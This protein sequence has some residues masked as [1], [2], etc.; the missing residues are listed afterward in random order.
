MNE[1]GISLFWCGIQATLYLLAGGLLYAVMRR[2]GPAPGASAAASTLL[3]LCC[4]SAAAFSPWPRGWT[5]LASESPTSEITSSAATAENVEPPEEGL[6]DTM[7]ASDATGKASLPPSITFNEY[8]KLFRAELEAARTSDLPTG[9]SRR[10]PSIIAAVLLASVA[11]A[12]ARILCGMAAMRR[13]RAGMLAIDD[14]RLTELAAIL[15]LQMGCHR[16][17]ELKQSNSLA[18]P[19]TMGWR[20]PLIVLP[21]DWRA[22]TEEERRVVLAHEIAHIARGDY[23]AWLVAQFSV[24]L[25]VYHPLV[26]WLAGRLR[27]EQELAADDWAAEMSGGREAYLFTLAQMALRQDDRRVAWAARPFLPSRGTFL[28]RIEM[29]SE[30]KPLRNVPVSRRRAVALA[31]VAALAGLI[32]SGVRA[33]FGAPRAAQAAPADKPKATPTTT[34][35]VAAIGLSYVPPRTVALL[36]ARPAD[37]LSD[38][39]MQPLVKLLNDNA[40]PGAGLNIKDIEEIKVAILRWREP[41]AAVPVG[42]RPRT[43]QEALQETMLYTIRYKQ[44]FDWRGKLGEDLIGE[45]VEASIAGKTYYRSGRSEAANRPAMYMPDDRTVVI[46]PEIE[47]QRTI[48][49]A[50]KSKIEW[51]GEWE[52]SAKGQAAVMVDLAA[53]NRAAGEEISRQP[54]QLG[55]MAVFTP[56]WTKGQRLF[57]FM[58]SRKG[59]G[60]EARIHCLNVEDA[61][62]VEATLQAAVTLAGNLLDQADRQVAKATAAQAAAL[63]PLIDLATEA[64]KQGKLRT[65]A[66]DVHYATA[67]DLDVAET[68]ISTVTP[69]IVAARSAAQQSQANNNLRQIGIALHNYNDTYGHFPPPVIIGPDGKMPHSWRVAILPF[70][71]GKPLY[72]QYQMDEPWDSEN[73]KKILAQMPAAL[74]DPTADPASSSTSYFALV[75]PTTAFGDKDSKGTKIQDITDG[76][77]ITIA[78]VEAKRSIPW[79]KPEDIDYDPAKPLPKLGGWHAGGFLASLCD[80]SVHFLADTLA[81]EKLRALITKAGGELVTVP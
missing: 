22:W 59:L 67:L 76:T 77:S 74:R 15:S 11:L 60:L 70:I 19:A 16:P 66:S 80:G 53:F 39:D 45:P 35:D 37:I 64:L 2:F 63:V 81:E 43:P 42:Q 72:D 75:G 49:A 62:Q 69:A 1:L 47:L 46:G 17:I 36:A 38:P 31:A 41:G 23:I 6:P 56:I 26:H 57:V 68:V 34:K 14:A 13:Y 78:V 21:A 52:K 4:V 50:G 61:K 12:L 3:V 27:L 9:R 73:N 8:W 18:T 20:R 55:P 58:Q 79:T 10:W 48:A 44:P 24:A 32:V 54:R 30:T 51:A 5:L 28:R 7:P 71:E 25:H 33:P 65:Q 40:S 29:L